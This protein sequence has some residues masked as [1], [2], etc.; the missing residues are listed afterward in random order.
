M[1][2]PNNLH[3]SECPQRHS[4]PKICFLDFGGGQ[5]GVVAA[6]NATARRCSSFITISRRLPGR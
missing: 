4:S 3:L 6:K 5:E 2:K 1:Q